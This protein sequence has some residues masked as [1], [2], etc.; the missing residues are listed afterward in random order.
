MT[1]KKI[2]LLVL[3]NLILLAGI[4][5][6]FTVT[7]MNLNKK[8]ETLSAKITS[9]NSMHTAD[10]AKINKLEKTVNADKAAIDKLQKIVNANKV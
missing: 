5:T 6:V 4:C 8:N 10:E 3:L 7:C 2:T 9:L 1:K